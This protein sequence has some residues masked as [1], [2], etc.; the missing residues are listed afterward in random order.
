MPTAGFV[1]DTDEPLV[2]VESSE[3]SDDGAQLA[4]VRADD[5]TVSARLA[6]TTK[7]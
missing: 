1:E 7:E 2:Q 6:E 3:S 4:Q 5:M